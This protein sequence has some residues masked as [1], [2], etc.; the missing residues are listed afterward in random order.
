M[1][2][3]SNVQSFEKLLGICT[4]YGGSYNPGKQNLRVEILSDLLKQAQDKLLQVSI[5]KSNH[6]QAQ[7]ERE[8]AFT[9]MR[10]LTSRIMAELRSSGALPQTIADASV[11]ARRI[12]GYSKA[13]KAGITAEKGKASEPETASRK[14]NSAD[15]ANSAAYLEK[16][17]QTLGN[18]PRYQPMNPEL[19][20]ET[21]QAMLTRLRS[22]NAAVVNAYAAWSNARHERTTFL[23]LGP[24]CLHNTAMAMKHQVQATFGFNS[25]AHALVRKVHFTKLIK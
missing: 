21:L 3:V 4:G 10:A 13:D 11:M 16:L 6:E 17:L 15:F 14:R 18:E 20:L 25:E 8:I 24:E 22:L 23:Y 7:N 2:H 9:E 19:Q 1:T 12:R 5:A